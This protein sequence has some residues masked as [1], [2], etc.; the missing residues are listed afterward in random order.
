MLKK[1][2]LTLYILGS[3]GAPFQV[4]PADLVSNDIVSN[5]IVSNDIVS[6][7]IAPVL[8]MDS[9]LDQDSKLAV[10]PKE[11]HVYN[12]SFEELSQYKVTSASFFARNAL[13]VA[14]TVKVIER[15]D[16]LRDGSRRMLDL[17]GQQ[18]GT[19]LL[20]SIY[21]LNVIAIRG[22]ARTGSARGIATRLDGIP[23]N[24]PRRGSGQISTQNIEL[25]VLDSIEVVRG[26]GSALYG[27][28]AFH[29]VIAMSAFESEQDVSRLSAETGVNNFYQTAV[30]HSSGFGNGARVN[31]AIAASG[32][33]LE[34][35]YQVRDPLTGLPQQVKPDESTASKTAT[36]K[37]SF[38]PSS[39]LKLTAGL[40]LDDYDTFNSPCCPGVVADSNS[41]SRTQAGQFIATQQLGGDNTLQ[42]RVYYVDSRDDY[43]AASVSVG[44]GIGDA[45]SS[46]DLSRSGV[47]LIYRHPEIEGFNTQFAFGL[48]YETANFKNGYI[49]LTP[50]P[51]DGTTEPQELDF[52]GQGNKRDITYLLLNARTV[53]PDER[54]SVNYG[55]RLDE[56]SDEGTV[57]TPR[58][59]FIF[60]PSENS[61]FKLLY[62]KAFRA[63]SI[64]E[65]YSVDDLNIDPE[66][67]DS[68]EFVF[69]T[70]GRHWT[71]EIVLFENHW[72]DAITFALDASQP[73]GFTY[74][75]TGENEAQGL[76]ASF[77]WQPDGPW[78]FDV[79]GSY[80]KSR[81]IITEQD[82]EL[83]PRTMASIGIGR[84]FDSL[85]GDL[86]I[87]NH[88]FDQ[89]K[90]T[91]LP[92]AKDLPL[93]WRTDLVFS[94]SINK[95]LNFHI[96][97]INLFGRD[98]RW[99]S[100]L[101]FAEGVADRPFSVSI[102]LRYRM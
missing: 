20:P 63:P 33:Q 95:K 9:S 75:N 27:S 15:D 1:C 61:A 101:G 29:G 51:L 100:V 14:S 46:T 60:Q 44:P 21:G 17:V 26:P 87:T 65:R 81:N 88:I 50:H 35:S 37:M 85:E 5:D 24:E 22:Y 99:P 54:W 98:N 38:K 2:G 34:R 67:L 49:V 7:D 8:V 80:I 70:G 3:L 16:W 52:P 43:F 68:Y 4:Y 30:Q 25:G 56:Y 40:Y 47:E 76:E 102:G 48:G 59:G 12:L 79:S 36:L 91:S 11:F 82:Y 62:N 89:A 41:K 45:E 28:D 83:F 10:L 84:R 6:N 74:K 94:K 57:L 96:N 93:Y 55:G 23:I 53:L 39:S 64:G 66:T 90:D 92:T 18:P 42:A 69:L 58:L 31:L 32:E 77:T 72:K 19:M 86:S 71:S 78:R 73:A 97:A 13:T